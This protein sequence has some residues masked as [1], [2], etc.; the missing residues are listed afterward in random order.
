MT[1]RLTSPPVLPAGCF[2][3]DP[4]RVLDVLLSSLEARPERHTFLIPLLRLYMPAAQT[5]SEVVGARYGFCRPQPGQDETEA[6]TPRPLHVMTA[7]LL[8]HG[9]I[10]L[11]NIWP[12]VS[13][14]GGWSG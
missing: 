14:G 12:W 9:V 11:E 8:R 1:S 3:L 5:V 6:V 13:H 7:L 4:N 2:N 10:T